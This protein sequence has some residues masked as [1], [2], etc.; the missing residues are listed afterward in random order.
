M[1]YFQVDRANFPCQGINILYVKIDQTNYLIKTKLIC[2]KF[3]F[4]GC[5]RDGCGNANGRVEFN[6]GICK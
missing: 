3:I 4:Q 5:T 1:C 6:P 2:A